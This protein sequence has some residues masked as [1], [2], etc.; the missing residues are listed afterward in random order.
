MRDWEPMS[1]PAA[2]RRRADLLDRARGYFKAHDILAVDTPALS[3]YAASDPNI[4]SL[5]VRAQHD[6]DLFLHTSPEF[7]MKRLLA[8]GYP[9][10]YSI[11]RVFRDGEIGMRHLPEFTLIEWYRLGFDLDAIIGDTLRLLATCLDRPRLVKSSVQHNYA[12]AFAAFAGVDVFEASEEKLA[13][14]CNA[15]P[16]LRPEIGVHRDAWLDLILGTIIAPQFAHDCLTVVRHF[17]SSQAG[18]ARLC[19]DDQRVADRFEVFCGD[20]ELANG[21]VELRDAEEQ[22]HRIEHDLETRQRDGRRAYPPDLSLIDALDA[23]LP[24]CAGVAVGVER[25]HMTLD[26]TDDIRDVVTFASET[27]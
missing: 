25:L 2:A 6:Q 5:S 17:P 19:P 18:L 22:R 12:D 1:G 13:D 16:G 24:A 21:Y 14:R 10:I 23:G 11:C 26:Q 3:K 8:G 4:D 20:V 9:D 7:A 15:D 27:S